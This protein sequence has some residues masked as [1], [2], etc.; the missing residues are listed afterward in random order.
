[1]SQYLFLDGA[2]ECS[3]T[4]GDNYNSTTQ[5]CQCGS[6]TS[7]L[8]SLSNSPVCN[9]GRCKCSKDVPACVKD[10]EICLEGVCWTM[11][12]PINIVHL[13]QF[14]ISNLKDDID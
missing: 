3:G 5:S 10:I 1:M 6:E 14:D 7:C 9:A 11:G 8:M 4:Y 13:A 2:L 12:N